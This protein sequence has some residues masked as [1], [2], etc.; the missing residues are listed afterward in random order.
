MIRKQRGP[1]EGVTAGT[2]GSCFP[3]AEDKRPNPAEIRKVAE[4]YYRQGDFYCSEAIVKTIKEAFRLPVPDTIIAMA[5]GFPVGMG[6][7]GCTCGAIVGGIMALGL[8]FGRTE[9]RD[10]KV[11]KAMELSRE[12]HDGF[13][14]RH[15][16]LC[17]RLLTKDM[18]LGSSVQMRQCIAFTG[19]VAEETSKLILR[20]MGALSNH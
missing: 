15:K 3:A 2:K 19:E 1:D 10:S 7:A 8:F 11:A 9:P 14:A 6:R 4:N 17:C 18:R 20:E 16:N 12:L 13:R 5:S